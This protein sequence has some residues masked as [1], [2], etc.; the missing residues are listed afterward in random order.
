MSIKSFFMKL[1]F[2]NYKEDKVVPP[3]APLVEKSHVAEYKKTSVDPRGL[4]TKPH[5]PANQRF[6]APQKA[7]PKDYGFDEVAKS[8]PNDSM[9]NPAAGTN[10]GSVQFSSP[11]YHDTPSSRSCSGSSYSSSDCSSSSDGGGGGD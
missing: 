1:I 3:T 11:S 6:G 7:A 9:W 5:G 8:M 2:K 4:V 10:R